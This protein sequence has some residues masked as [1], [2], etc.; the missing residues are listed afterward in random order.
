[1]KKIMLLLSCILLTTIASNAQDSTAKK[2]KKDRYENHVKNMDSTQKQ[3]LK[4]KGITRE[5][6]KNLDLSEDQKKQTDKIFTDT[7]KS[8]DKIKNDASLSE[9]QKDEKLKEIDKEA[10][11]KINAILTP[12]QKEK[13]KKQKEKNKKGG[14]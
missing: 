9:T 10:K 13:I 2:T 1:M 14:Q 8:K 7:K 4:D 5:N 6:L 3:N 12:E 11:N